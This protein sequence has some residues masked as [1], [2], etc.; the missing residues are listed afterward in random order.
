[1]PDTIRINVVAVEGDT[2]NFRVVAIT[3]NGDEVPAFVIS[4][5]EFAATKRA[6]SV[7]ILDADND[8]LIAEAAVVDSTTER[9][10][11]HVSANASA[12]PRDI[13]GHIDKISENLDIHHEAQAAARTIIAP[14]VE[15]Q[16]KEEAAVAR[17]VR[18]VLSKIGS[19]ASDVL[20]E[21]DSVR[22]AVD[23]A[24]ARWAGA[25]GDA[26]RPVRKVRPPAAHL[27][28]DGSL[29]DDRQ[30]I[31]GT[32]LSEWVLGRSIDS[33]GV[34]RR[35]P[36]RDV[37]EAQIRSALGLAEEPDPP[38]PPADNTGTGSGS[39]EGTLDDLVLNKTAKL[40]EAIGLPPDAA[41]I[42][43]PAET[44]VTG[45]SVQQWSGG[46]ADIAAYHDFHEL[47]LALPNV[48][49]QIFNELVVDLVFDAVRGLRA[50]ESDEAIDDDTALL[51][52]VRGVRSL[53]NALT[54]TPLEE[55]GTLYSI[56][57]WAWDKIKKV[58]ESIEDVFTGEG[59]ITNGGSSKPG[60]EIPR[61]EAGNSNQA[62]DDRRPNTNLARD[63]ILREL[64]RGLR[65]N[66]T[67]RY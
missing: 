2:R 64:N 13:I 50:V 19:T 55:L 37:G 42:V 39:P 53:R 29:K 14:E 58:G 27:D 1:M 51:E 16:R 17:D 52:V 26:E 8:T 24:A 38:Q 10:D 12:N 41:L 35:S 33:D 66:H 61:P 62:T 23:V 36:L 65:G 67:S 31:E 11:V 47:V 43:D 54:D 3:A 45:A 7:R 57:D 63:Q 30:P 40:V 56:R 6:A 18:R 44:G 15:R 49:Q 34:L 25:N 22:N 46:L 48:W 32:N 4:D 59:T 5:K 21:G 28:A 60:S 20:Q 9:V